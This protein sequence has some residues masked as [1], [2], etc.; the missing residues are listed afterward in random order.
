MVRHARAACQS[1]LLHTPCALEAN[2]TVGI[3]DLA[4]HVLNC[5]P[6]DCVPTASATVEVPRVA[7]ID[8][9]LPHGE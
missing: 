1:R 4:G 2:G 6:H 5:E 9:S 8:A 3:R 7:D